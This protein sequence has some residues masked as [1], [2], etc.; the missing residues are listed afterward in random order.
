METAKEPQV[1]PAKLSADIA[2]KYELKGIEPGVVKTPS[3]EIDLTKASL[4]Q[5]EK[6]SKYLKA[7]LVEKPAPAAAQ[8]NDP[9]KPAAT[10]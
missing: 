6:H 4:A 5:V 3:G 1:Q 10:T 2:S 8:A 9:K 7:Y